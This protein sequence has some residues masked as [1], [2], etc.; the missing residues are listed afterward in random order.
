MSSEL[1]ATSPEYRQW[2]ADLKGRFRQVQL[3]AAVAVNSALLDFYWS[4]GTDILARQNTVAWGQGFL[5]QLSAD[6][7]ADFPGVAGFSKR[8]LEQ[9]RRWV[10]FWSRA[11]QIAKQAAS[12]SGVQTLT[13]KLGE[14]MAKGAELDALIRQKLGGL[15]YEF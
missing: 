8:N 3:K 1:S 12:Q 5:T 10:S 11:P 15:G 9:M 13:A 2:L 7:M 14:Q 4:L 6:L